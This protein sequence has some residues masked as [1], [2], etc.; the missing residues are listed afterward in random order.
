MPKKSSK[1]KNKGKLL[2]KLVPAWESR[3]GPAL[4]T[5]G[6]IR[7]QRLQGPAPF[8]YRPLQTPASIRL[9]QLKP[10]R[11]DEPISCWLFEVR[12][13]DWP[14]YQAL[15]YTWGDPD[16]KSTIVCNEGTVSIPRNL[17]EG[18][19]VLRRP[20]RL[21]ILWADAVCINQ[22]D[23]K[24]RGSQVQLMS[25]IFSEASRV[26]AWLGHGQPSMIRMTFGY[27]CAAL[28]RKD[29]STFAN[30]KWQGR[31]V[32][33][34]GGEDEISRTP[35]YEP[36]QTALEHL[37]ES[38]YFRRGWII[39]EIVLPKSVE[40]FW[41]EACINYLSMESA[42]QSLLYYHSARFHYPA[43]HGMRA[44][45]QIRHLREL[46][47]DTLEQCPF[48]Q[49]LT[50]AAYQGFSDPRDHI[51]G[52]LGLQKICRDMTFKRPLFYPD[53]TISHLECYKSAV[54]TLL[55]EREDLGILS[56][57]RHRSQI[58]KDSPSWVPRFDD[59]ISTVLRWHYN[60]WR[61]SGRHRAILSKQKHNGVDCMRLRG[62]RVATLGAVNSASERDQKDV[63]ILLHSLQD[64]YDERSIA[65]TITYGDDVDRQALWEDPEVEER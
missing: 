62:L 3:D 9:L 34:F 35:P 23:P 38:P 31:E 41:G 43:R 33:V 47:H 14:S 6:Q 48:T 39:Q 8:K 7:R 44:L 42:N 36:T 54:E 15:S 21:R 60:H 51:Y 12:L 1:P 57:I 2:Q 17:A 58:A 25:R 18:L 16:D 27:I 53:Y 40:I 5:I 64:R 30:Y 56:L 24:E 13:D 28:N 11:E 55:T 4:T 65:W 32:N 37:F 10:G 50:H 19:R 45:D 22:K 26:L 52:L 29:K 61:A 20:D 46:L 59:K 63:H 49:I